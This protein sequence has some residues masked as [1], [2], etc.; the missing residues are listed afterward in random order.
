MYYF[1]RNR[2]LYINENI[3]GLKK[4]VATIYTCLWIVKK[5]VT[6]QF[7]YDVVAEGVYDYI[8]GI[9]GEK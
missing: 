9:K 5:I 7:N 8:K 3:A 4:I 2:L 1:T 6:G